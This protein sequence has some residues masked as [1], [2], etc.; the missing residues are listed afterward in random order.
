MYNI[1]YAY[2]YVYALYRFFG[3]DRYEQLNYLLCRKL[4]YSCHKKLTIVHCIYFEH[5]PKPVNDGKKYAIE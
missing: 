3:I 5:T 4:P 1:V 2:V